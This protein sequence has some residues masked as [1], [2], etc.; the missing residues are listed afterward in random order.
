MK[1][2]GTNITAYLLLLG[3]NI[4]GQCC[5]EATSTQVENPYY[6]PPPPTPSQT[7]GNNDG[8]SICLSIN[9]GTC[10]AAAQRFQDATIYHQYTSAV[11]PDSTGADIA[12]SIFPVVGPAI[13]DFFGINYG[14]TV[15]WECDNSD[16]Y[17]QG[18]TGAQIKDA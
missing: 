14:C 2:C 9:G 11:W 7:S 15:I 1:I 4:F 18:M 8:S 6:A 17:T 13:E 12:N 5:S 3:N 16:A 10:K